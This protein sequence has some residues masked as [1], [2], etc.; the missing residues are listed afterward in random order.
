MILTTSWACSCNTSFVQQMDPCKIMVV[1]IETT[2][3]SYFQLM[4]KVTSNTERK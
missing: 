4:A 3:F 1:K 2:F